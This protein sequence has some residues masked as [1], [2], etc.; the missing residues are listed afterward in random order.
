MAVT[1]TWSIND[2]ERETSDNYICWVHW[3]IK[4]SEDS[5]TFE[6]EGKTFLPRPDTLVDYATLTE[7]TVIG[8]VKAKLNSD[9]PAVD[10]EAT[11]KTAVQRL[12][13]EIDAR[14]A[15]LDTSATSTGKPF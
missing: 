11:G 10:D 8:W 14:I 7:E 6:M 2:L 3:S 1:K 13:D 9:S 15:A 12:E 5:K 4:G